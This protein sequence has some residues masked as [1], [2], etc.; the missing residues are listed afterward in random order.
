MDGVYRSSHATILC[1]PL[2]DHPR[3]PVEI[4]ES[5]VLTAFFLEAGFLGVTLFGWNRV[6]PGLHFGAT[7]MVAVGTVIS[8]FWILASNSWMHPTRVTRS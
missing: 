2:I 1:A 3:L 8:P 4:E 5:E 7:V 6:G